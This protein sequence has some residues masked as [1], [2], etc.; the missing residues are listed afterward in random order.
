MTDLSTSYMGIKMKSPVIAGSSGMTNSLS[1]IIELEK[2]GA[3]AVVLKSLFE[4][5]ILFEAGR[6]MNQTP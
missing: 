3:G 5:Q 1:H 4:E 2:A 6:V